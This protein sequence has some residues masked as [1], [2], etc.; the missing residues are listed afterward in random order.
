VAAW[1]VAAI[2]CAI[3]LGQ[4]AFFVIRYERPLFDAVASRE[5]LLG[6]RYLTTEMNMPEIRVQE[7][8]FRCGPSR[9]YVHLMRTGVSLFVAMWAIPFAGLLAFAWRRGSSGFRHLL[10]LL[11]GLAPLAALELFGLFA[12]ALHAEEIR[13]HTELTVSMR[14]EPVTWAARAAWGSLA[15]VAAVSWWR[16]QR[17]KA[18]PVDPEVF[19]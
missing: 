10:L 18:T 19:E 16:A 9:T 4:D 6:C 1:L 17:G 15:V 7:V 8:Y 13:F 2:V 5:S 12:R 11:A 14:T 3:A